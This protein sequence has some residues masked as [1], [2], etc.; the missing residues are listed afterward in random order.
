MRTLL[1]IVLGVVLSMILF[2]AEGFFVINFTK[3]GQVTRDAL[4]SKNPTDAALSQKYGGDPF[5]LIRSTQRT[6]KFVLGPIIAIAVGLLGGFVDRTRPKFSAGLALTPWVF[7]NLA[8]LHWQQACKACLGGDLALNALYLG[9]GILAAHYCGK[10]VRGGTA[11]VR[12][13][14]PEGA[15]PPR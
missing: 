4:F 11:P 13:A 1:A 14:M 10:L 5:E 7:L 15:R 2:F 12:V 8:H 3:G 6:Q 9:I